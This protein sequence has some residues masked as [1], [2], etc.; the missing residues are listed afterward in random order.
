MR[1]KYG[2]GGAI[3]WGLRWRL[4]AI[5][6][7]GPFT[8]K[9]A[10]TTPVLHRTGPRVPIRTRGV[11]VLSRAHRPCGDTS[12][13]ATIVEPQRKDPRP[14]HERPA[15]MPRPRCSRSAIRFASRSSAP[16]TGRSPVVRCRAGRMAP[17]DR[18]SRSSVR[19]M[20]S[21]ATSRAI[22]RCDWRG[23]IGWRR[24]RSRR[25]SRPSWPPSRRAT[26]RDAGPCGR[27][28][29]TRVPQH[30]AP[31]RTA[32]GCH[33][34]DPGRPTRLGTGRARPP[35]LGQRRVRVGQPDRAAPRRECPRGVHRRPAEPGPR[36]RRPAGDARVLLQ[37]LG[38]PDPEPRGVGRGAAT[39]R[40]GPRRR[41]QGRLRQRPG[42]GAPGRGVGERDGRRRRH[43]RAD[44]PLGGGP[45]AR[46]HRG[47]PRRRSASG[48]TSGRARRGSTTRAGSSGRSSA[49]A[50]AATSTSR[51]AR[52]GSAR[53]ISGTTR[54]GSSS[55]RTASRPTSP[56]TS[57]T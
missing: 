7:D 47:E 9:L 45:R 37:R 54:T 40:A 57:A 34:G 31:R 48:S 3:P 46:G 52:S 25:R 4:V 20:P 42:G 43:R 6:C 35:A 50:S 51:T 11:W 10:S 33:R 39:R 55:A 8:R 36:G 56:P 24:W 18:R 53:P 27:G 22:S 28:R 32:R 29:A 14:C 21:T 5:V 26:R 1:E 16:G 17:T 23:R 19:P 38:R 15:V 49:C 44:R 12:G 2:V 30:A 13:S 41:L